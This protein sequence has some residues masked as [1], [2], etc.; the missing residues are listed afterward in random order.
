[1]S[2]QSIVRAACVRISSLLLLLSSVCGGMTYA[3]APSPLPSGTS[4]IA[5]KYPGDSNIKSDPNVIFAD[6]F[7][8]YSS[9]SQL[10]GNWDN[11]YQQQNVQITTTPANVFAGQ[12]TLEMR[13]PAQ[14]TNV[15]N[16]VDKRMNPTRDLVFV[17][18][19]TKFVPGYNITGSE[20]NGISVTSQYCCPG[21]PANGTNKFYVDVENGRDLASANPGFT[22]AY[23]YYPQQRGSYGDHW[24][25]DGIVLPG[26]NTPGNFGPYFVPRTNFIPNLNQWYCYEMMV[27][28]NT[29]GLRDGRVAIWIDGNLIADFQNLRLR[30]V[31]TLKIDLVSLTLYIGANPNPIDMLKWYDNMVIATSYIGPM[32]SATVAPPTNLTAIVN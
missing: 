1:M 9:G 31:N 21:V 16:G 5:S 27:Q 28:A 23:V 18:V 11:V 22:N 25:P 19:Y 4:G 20:H 13:V 8:S 26:S 3:Q 6:D 15:G 17:R 12:R 24:F 10:W 7:E 32:S 30:D 29:P 14:T 2:M